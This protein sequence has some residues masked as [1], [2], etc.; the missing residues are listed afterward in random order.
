MLANACE[1]GH[2]AVLTTLLLIEKLVGISIEESVSQLKNS[3][4]NDR[5]R[6]S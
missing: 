1:D 6:V 2:F 4:M 5:M 3:V